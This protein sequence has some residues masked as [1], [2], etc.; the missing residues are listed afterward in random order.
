MPRNVKKIVLALVIVTSLSACGPALLGLGK[1]SSGDQVLCT[2]DPSAE[3]VFYPD[4]VYRKSN[5]TVCY[6]QEAPPCVYVSWVDN[7]KVNFVTCS[8]AGVQLMNPGEVQN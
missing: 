1:H 5:V 8:S 2:A 3:M 6:R 4:G 7:S